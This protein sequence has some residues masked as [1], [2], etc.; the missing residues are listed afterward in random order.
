[1][2]P[3]RN[4]RHVIDS[5]NHHAIKRIRRLHVRA[6]RD[7]TGL[8]YVEGMRFIAQAVQHRVPIEVL[9][10]CRPLLTHPFARHLVRQLRQTGTPILEVTPDVLSSVA[11]VDDPQGIGAVV[12]QR[13]TPLER[14]VPAN[15]SC[16]IMLDTVRSPG[17]L[18]TILRTSEAVGGAGLIL[19]GEAVD[20]YDPATVRASMGS[21]F[22]QRF[23]RTTVADVLRWKDRQQCVLVGTAPSAVTDYQAVDYHAPTVLLLGGERK[24][25]SSELRALCDVVVR[26]PM[27]GDTDSLNL[28]VAASLLLY[29]VFN[30]RRRGASPAVT[31]G[32]QQGDTPFVQAACRTDPSDARD[33]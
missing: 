25:L 27:L 1:M 30:Q 31:H 9:V 10:T 13:W 14:I 15:D 17:N 5:R 19:L 12:R 11:L 20:P 2:T 24:G 26:I 23:V 6:E 3:F 29:E 7:R 18:G 21:L 28:S 16:W 8:S 32:A 33:H 22:S 4:H